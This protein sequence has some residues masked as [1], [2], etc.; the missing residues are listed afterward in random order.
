[1]DACVQGSQQ[2]FGLGVPVGILRGV[3]DDRL[4]RG[5]KGI[6]AF[7][8]GKHR[9]QKWW[10]TFGRQLQAEGYLQ[11]NS[12]SAYG[13]GKR[14]FFAATLGVSVKGTQ[15]RFRNT[16][17]L[18]MLPNQELRALTGTPRMKRD[19]TG[20]S[21]SGESGRF[22]RAS[23]REKQSLARP[24]AAV[25]TATE[26]WMTTRR[27]SSAGISTS[28]GFVAHAAHPAL[29]RTQSS[30]VE[31]TTR[32]TNSTTADVPPQPAGNENDS[33]SWMLQDSAEY[34]ESF[35]QAAKEAEAFNDKVLA[36]E[37][38]LLN[39]LISW[40]KQKAR[41]RGVAPYQVC[42]NR[43]LNG[44]AYA[45]PCNTSELQALE[46]VST[47]FTTFYGKDI[48][49]I[50]C[51]F[52][53]QHDDV[54][55]TTV[56]QSA[57]EPDHGGV[58]NTPQS[59]HCNNGMQ[60]TNPYTGTGIKRSS[61]TQQLHHGKRACTAHDRN[62]DVH[63][64]A[65]ASASS[66]LTPS[67]STKPPAAPHPTTLHAGE[68]NPDDK[69]KCP[70]D[71]GIKV[72]EP[73]TVKLYNGAHSTAMSHDEFEE[74]GGSDNEDFS[75][76]RAYESSIDLMNSDSF[77]QANVNDK[78]QLEPKARAPNT[79]NLSTLLAVPGITLD[80]GSS[81][82]RAAV[83][84][85]N[86]TTSNMGTTC[87][88]T[89]ANSSSSIN[90]AG[91]RSRAENLQQLCDDCEEYPASYFCVQC[92]MYFCTEC[93]GHVRGKRK[94]HTIRSMADHT[95]LLLQP[96]PP[97]SKDGASN[98]PPEPRAHTATTPVQA[99]MSASDASRARLMETYEV[100][101]PGGQNVA[102]GH[103]AVEMHTQ[104]LH[105][106]QKHHSSIDET[107]SAPPPQLMR[108]ATPQMAPITTQTAVLSATRPS[109]ANR[110]LQKVV[111][112]DPSSRGRA[113][114]VGKMGGAQPTQ[115]G[116]PGQQTNTGTGPKKEDLAKLKPA[117][118]ETVCLYLQGLPINVIRVRQS[119]GRF[120]VFQNLS[121][122][123]LHDIALDT[124]L[125]GASLCT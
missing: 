106:A 75:D 113:P 99:K 80:R 9:N 72:P 71:W 56:P 89:P 122:A 39:Q 95:S 30:P 32:R 83:A 61:S 15:W 57:H 7:G 114:P 4:T 1:M 29:S 90:Q 11:S 5:G 44:V 63:T 46:G 124:T 10:M 92:D 25:L 16:G 74:V 123:F 110:P 104:Q 111:K 13:G 112:H 55:N 53:N 102:A 65:D 23:S 120:A 12:S 28:V 34:E 108:Q 94:T 109:Y 79:A 43:V 125:A 97:A 100:V 86:V 17:K 66:T 49:R 22:R 58:S 27:T 98:H 62:N 88:P 118:R 20:A 87:V 77:S 8:E 67:Y 54:L 91:E 85:G 19:T 84:T 45:R 107:T 103:A 73:H 121:Q 64:T 52:T 78:K 31:L 105:H 69:S 21:F 36:L 59:S 35:C 2:R 116:L 82:T 117:V 101:A 50:C 47:Q 18:E 51:A 96:N 42:D 60:P 119:L 14:S 115:S 48:L 40:R 6:L 38:K 76:S 70:E 24:T 33:D 3:T 93:L 81:T 41:E 26:G 37:E 68:N